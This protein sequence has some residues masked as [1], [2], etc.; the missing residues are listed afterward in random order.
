VLEEGREG[1]WDK[2]FFREEKEWRERTGFH[3]GSG[4]GGSKD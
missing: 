3:P 4:R 1:K 2:D